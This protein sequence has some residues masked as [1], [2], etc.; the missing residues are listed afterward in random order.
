[1]NCLLQGI[2]DFQIAHGDALLGPK[3]VEG[4]GLMR[5]NVVPAKTLRCKGIALGLQVFNGR[6]GKYP[7][8]ADYPPVR[9]GPAPFAFIGHRHRDSLSPAA[10][11]QE[12]LL[13]STGR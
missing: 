7:E 2:E 12:Y 6:R 10:A 3:L 5:F 13:T 4:D 1:M 9:H 8:C 11:R